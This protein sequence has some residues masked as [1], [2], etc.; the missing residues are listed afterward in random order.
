MGRERIHENV[1]RRLYAESMGRCM[2]PSCQKELFISDEDIAEKAHIR[3][4]CKDADNSYENLIILCPNCHK[5]FDKVSAFDTDEVKNWKLV[6]KNELEKVFSKRCSSFEELKKKVLPLLLENRMIYEN[7]YLGDKRVLWD[8]LET[9][10]L[11]NNRKLK[12]LLERNIGL[13]QS[14]SVKE[15]SNMECVRLFIAH[16]DEFETTRLDEEKC[17]QILYP[18]K[19]DS[20]FGIKSVRESFL[21]S[22]ESLEDLIAK[23]SDEGKFHSIYLGNDNPY[24]KIYEDEKLVTL[25][26]MDTPRLRQMYFEYKCFRG[27]KVR[28]NS[29][30]YAFKYM[31][32]RG[33]DFEF[34]YNDNLREILV[35]NKR[36]L[37]V[38]EYCLSKAHLLYLA[39]EEKSVIVNLHNWNGCCCISREAYEVASA[40][41]I[42]LLTMDDFYVYINRIKNSK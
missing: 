38:Y 33:V 21:P 32:S 11:V 16:I 28:L 1:K 37:F 13:F 34:I 35:C 10:I 27:A 14:H 20:I 6:R 7:Y 4:Y 3:P 31:R 25:F 41:G 19:I 42:T 18:I 26:L 40:L 39:P 30:N 5:E 23:L 12:V 8:K 15:Y 22:T 29:L 9:K 17:R 24:V 2:N 36:M